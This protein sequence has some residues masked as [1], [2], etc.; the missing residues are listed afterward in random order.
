MVLGTDRVEEAAVD[1]VRV[2]WFGDEYQM[3]GTGAL[4]LLAD[5]LRA[6][7]DRFATR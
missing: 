6:V 1:E 5:D 2:R 7:Q 3:S 4:R